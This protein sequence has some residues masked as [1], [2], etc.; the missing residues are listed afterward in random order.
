MAIWRERT[1]SSTS[2]R[3]SNLRANPGQG[4]SHRSRRSVP[5]SGSHDRLPGV[6]NGG[7][8]ATNQPT[9][10]TLPPHAQVIQMAFG[11]WASRALY[12]MAKLG[13]ADKLAGGPR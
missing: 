9:A 4:V 8:M 1:F 10:P 2:S 13:L 12:A 5:A 6:P 11:F 7:L 3:V